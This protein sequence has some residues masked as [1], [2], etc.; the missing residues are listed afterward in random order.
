MVRSIHLVLVLLLWAMGCAKGGPAAS[1]AEARANAD[2]SEPSASER[3]ASAAA[4]PAALPGSA[5][6]GAVPERRYEAGPR[7]WLGVEL[8]APRDGQPG[9]LVRRVLRGSPAERAGLAPGDVLVRLGELPIQEP[10]AVAQTVAQQRVGDVV[11]VAF[12]R[13]A[14]HRLTRARLEGQPVFEDLLRLS[15]VGLEAPALSGAVTF[16]G[17]AASLRELQGRVVLL[18]FW[19]S[20][21]G[22]CRYLA[23]ELERLQRAYR[24]AGLEV[25]G[26]TTDLPGPG[27]QAALRAGMGYTLAS[28]ASGEI[29]KSYLASQVPTVFVIDRRG[30][31]VDVMVGVQ[32]ARIE[33]LETRV[34]EL[35]DARG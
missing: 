3:G 18:E 26:I 12:L 1:S 29:T 33:E 14:E 5:A 30:I 35:L 7:P 17:E 31:V 34:R 32:A 28:D 9:V 22:V 4:S 11:P 10:S 16:Q 8:E 19:A 24:P 23:P 15:F 27:A 6:D 25:V 13:G 20:W 2:L 21:C